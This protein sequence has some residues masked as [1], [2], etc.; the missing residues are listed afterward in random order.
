MEVIFIIVL[1]WII[2]SALKKGKSQAQLKQEI[3]N[4][5]SEESKARMTGNSTGYNQNPVRQTN[6]TSAGSQ[7]Q[8]RTAVQKTTTIL[9][10]AIENTKEYVEDVTLNTLEAEHNHSERVS[11]AIHHHPEDVIPENLLGSVED[12]MVKGY[13]GNLCFE[14]DFLGEAIDMINRFTVSSEV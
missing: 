14:R 9:E 12:L 1:V 13:D 11:A 2:K 7:V 3:W 4:R 6:H 8:Q 5:L 10:R